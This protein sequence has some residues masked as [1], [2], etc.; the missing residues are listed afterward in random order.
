MKLGLV[1]VLYKSD[2]VLP[3][4]FRSIYV[5]TFK[6]YK[7]YL[8]DNSPSIK[9]K[10][11]IAN[12]QS[13]YSLTAIE[14]IENEHNVGVAAANNIGIKKA[15]EDKCADQIILNNDIVFNNPN[16][17]DALIQL[18]NKTNHG[19]IAPKIFFYNSKKIWYAGSSFTKWNVNVKHRGEFE[20][21]TN[22]YLSGVTPYAPTCFVYVKKEVFE[23]VGLMDERYFVYVDDVD[24]MYRVVKHGFS[25]WYENNLSLEHKISQSTG[26]KFSDFSLYYTVRNRI[27]FARKFYN[28][29]KVFIAAIY[30]IVSLT[31]HTIFTGKRL[32]ALHKI[33]KAVKA[34]YQIP[35]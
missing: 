10:N 33:F 8:I 31:Y 28:S 19:I 30:I 35:C 17:F 14:H 3:D 21:D 4:F 12:L 22:K 1:T 9:T 23:K 24:F 20:E 6:N 16:L 25:I 32:S 18:A 29:P 15:I 5:Q 27:F 11:I 2:D 34:G 26:G 13:T 7:L